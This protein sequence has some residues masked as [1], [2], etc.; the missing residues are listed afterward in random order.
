MPT[1]LACRER[2]LSIATTV[3]AAPDGLD[4]DGLL[5]ADDALATSAVAGAVAVVPLQRA[6]DLLLR[7]GSD[8]L[9]RRQVA[10][11]LVLEG[12]SCG[13]QGIRAHNTDE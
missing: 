3:S 13:L 1:L 7:L 6:T 12:E 5:V 11:V 10:A 8:E 2:R 9:L 4:V